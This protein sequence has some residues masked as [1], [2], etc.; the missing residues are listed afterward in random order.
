MHRRGPTQF[1]AMVAGV[2]FLGGSAWAQH[3]Q[4]EASHDE[5]KVKVRGPHVEVIEL[6]GQPGRHAIFIGDGPGRG[7]VGVEILPLTEELR[8]H[9]GVPEDRGVMVSRVV[10]DSP[11]EKAGLEAAD[12]VTSVDGEG[13]DSPATLSRMVRSKEPGDSVSLEVWR[14][15]RPESFEVGIAERH[16]RLDVI[17]EGDALPG[18]E[19]FEQLYRYFDGEEWQER[20]ERLQN[21]D[22]K[23][24]DERM[25]EVE[26]RLRQ[27]ERQVEETEP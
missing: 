10:P 2:L 22:W 7:H 15:G 11:A 19:V 21:L 6:D 3:P 13:I 16:H 14:D 12:I 18:T 1:S 23:S 17:R 5:V 24:I 4:H 20:V 25:R 9:F 8:R 26:E 27:L